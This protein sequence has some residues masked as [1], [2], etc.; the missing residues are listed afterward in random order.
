MN[1]DKIKEL[2]VTERIILVEDIWDSI[3]QD[4]ANVTLS[5]YEKR[6]LDERLNSLKENPDDLLSWTEIKAKLQR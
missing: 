4:Q 1:I 3:A 6:V 5:K 2:D